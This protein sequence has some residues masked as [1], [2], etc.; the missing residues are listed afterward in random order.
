MDKL[1]ETMRK[2]GWFPPA[3]PDRPDPLGFDDV[4][5]LVDR[6]IMGEKPVLHP[7]T[8]GERWSDIE[9]NR[10]PEATPDDLIAEEFEARDAAVLDDI[11]IEPENY[12]D[13]LTLAEIQ[14][15][16]LSMG[17]PEMD[18]APLSG[19]TDARQAARLLRMID[20]GS[21]RAADT[22]TSEGNLRGREGRQTLGQAPQAL[23]GRQATDTDTDT[24]IPLQR[25]EV[26]RDSGIPAGLPAKQTAGSRLLDGK[27]NRA[28]AQEAQR[29]GQ[30]TP[31][32]LRFHEIDPASLP[33]DVRR[34]LAEIGEATGTRVAVVRNLT[35]EVDRFN[36]VTSRDGVIYIDEN[37]DR[38]AVLVAAHEWVHQLRAD[39]PDA[40]ARLRDEA[41][42]HADM[43]AWINRMRDEGN[44]TDEDSATEELVA[45]AVADAM[46]DPAFLRRIVEE[47]GSLRRAARSFLRFLD[48]MLGR[49]RGRNTSA[50][51]RDVQA[52]RDELA[53]VL[54]EYQNRETVPTDAQM[55]AAAPEGGTSAFRRWFRNSAVT[56]ARGN[57]LAVYHGTGDE[58]DAFDSRRLSSATDHASAGLG[59]FFTPDREGAKSY[60]DTV[61][62]HT[63]GL[64]ASTTA[65]PGTILGAIAA[66]PGVRSVVFAHN[67]PS[68]SQTASAA[69]RQ[70]AVPRARGDEPVGVC[71]SRQS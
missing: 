53:A 20:E 44:R 28:R 55:E 71:G 7:D 15:R 32:E 12:D 3:P 13:A 31:P 61:L 62:Q 67:H 6:A 66:V 40:Y 36:G 30:P 39:Q 70:L 41:L 46:I 42:R 48:G 65:D 4:I 22:R 43:P 19:E 45:D 58:F 27:L 47:G 21:N 69:D 37:A 33:V 1:L 60:A 11:G 38:P 51:L 56:D 35:P 26:A 14:S 8:P 10:Y 16:A 24:E 2:E 54:L 52:F 49:V 59:F 23:A 5:E 57:P 34:A 25:R 29:Q 9:A 68:G 50:Y 63:V 64:M 17:V 18:I